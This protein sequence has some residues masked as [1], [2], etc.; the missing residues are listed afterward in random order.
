MGRLIIY[1][2]SDEEIRKYLSSMPIQ[3]QMNGLTSNGGSTSKETGGAI[4]AWDQIALAFRRRLEEAVSNGHAGQKNA[5]LI[6]LKHNGEIDLSLL[7]KASGVKSRHDYGGIGS[8]LTR[9]M[10]RAGGPK[11]WYTYQRHSAK[12]DDWVY[13]MI[14]ELVDPLKRAFGVQ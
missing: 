10:K 14:P 11:A 8:S 7:W 3:T 1:E 9:N 6:W 2:G 13:T 5:V 12:Q 4:S